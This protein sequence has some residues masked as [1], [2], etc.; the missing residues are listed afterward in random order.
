M[1]DLRQQ[2]DDMP[3]TMVLV[4]ACITMSFLTDPFSPTSKQLETWGWLSPFLAANGEPWRLVSGGF[5]HGGL[6]HIVCNMSALISLGPPLERSLGSLRFLLL[7]VVSLLGGSIAVCLTNHIDQPV[8]G[9]SGAIFGLL[10]ALVAMNMATGRHLLSFLDYEG[11]RRLLG[12]IGFYLVLGMLIP[13]ISN[14]AH[15]GGLLAGFFVTFLWL[16][17]PR[18]LGSLRQWRIAVGALFASLLFVSVYPPARWDTLWN[19]SVHET[20]LDRRHAMQRAAVMAYY[21]KAE[22][23]DADIEQ[24]LLAEIERPKATSPTTPND[25]A[26]NAPDPGNP[27]P[28][29]AP[30]KPK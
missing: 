6:L 3:V 28:D 26:G 8:V 7:Y 14:T 24:F 9:A 19:A 23:T 17:P 20:N 1:R 29:R 27:D 15:V 13:F 10:G 4:L 5:L 18:T 30:K 16:T 2:L 25:P 21:E 22:V 12:T 11:P